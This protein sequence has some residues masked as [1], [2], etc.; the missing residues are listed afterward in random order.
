MPHIRAWL[1]GILLAVF[2]FATTLPVWSDDALHTRIDA[3]IETK[4]ATAPAELC[5]DAEFLRRIYL[6]LNGTI[7]TA[8]EAR[9]FIQD[10]AT[11]KREK[12]VE[13]LLQQPRYGQR[14][15]EMF[16]VMLMERRGDNDEWTKFLK[17]SFENNKPWDQLVREILNPDAENEQTRGAA[18]F[19]TKRLEKYGQNPVDLPGLTRDVGRL[20][21]G[22]DV[23]CAQCHDHLFINDYKQADYQGLFAYVGHTFIRRDKKFPAVGEKLMKTKIEFQSVFGGEKTQIGPRIPGGEEVAIP[24]VKKGEE[25][26][27]PP[28]RKT[29]FPGIPKFSP[30]AELSKRLP[31]TSNKRFATNIA[32]RLWFVMMGRGIVHPL[33]LHHGDNPASYPELLD[34]L[35]QQIIAHKFDVQ[36]ML[37]EIA[38]SRTYQRSSLLPPNSDHVP[39]SSF[40]VAIEKPLSAEQLL[41]GT[42]QATGE[43]KHLTANAKQKPDDADGTDRLSD[44]RNRFLAAFANNPREPEVEFSP[45]VKAALFVLNDV[46]VL[47]WLQPKPG[48]LVERL[49][50]M[51]DSKQIAEELYLSVLTRFPT[52]EETA[53]VN[54]HLERNVKTRQQ[55]IGQLAWAL[56]ASTEF[57]VNH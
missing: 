17:S 25:Y 19:I 21:L 16:H 20:F 45:S 52:E 4:A 31:A 42:L 50:K 53:E 22:I 6:D 34:L 36:W 47:A 44:Y 43:D 15:R 46:D 27:K 26:T 18:F 9:K 8:Q 48:N 13:R 55:A 40:L 35:G 23:Q 49:S 7:P 38:L 41:S 56:L 37:R 29:Q 12:L 28:D 33:D 1:R 51:A 30:L 5:T 3:L 24:V 11:D 54:R 10:K 57:C 2:S 39:E 32:N 14:M